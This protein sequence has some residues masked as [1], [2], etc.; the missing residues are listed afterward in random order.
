MQKKVRN[1]F[2]QKLKI[3]TS[4]I[5]I[6]AISDLSTI[7]TI[8]VTAGSPTIVKIDDEKMKTVQQACLNYN[9][10]IIDFA[11]LKDTRK[12]IEFYLRVDV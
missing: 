12:Q 7:S 3:L 1:K 6:S 9:N 4:V 5:I 10:L 2:Y 8:T 11:N